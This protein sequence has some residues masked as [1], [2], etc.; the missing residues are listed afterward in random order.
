MERRTKTLAAVNI[1]ITRAR[2]TMA[3]LEEALRGSDA[4]S[5]AAPI[6]VLVV[7]H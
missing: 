7:C 6:H 5:R 2:E 3:Q 4:P 1:D